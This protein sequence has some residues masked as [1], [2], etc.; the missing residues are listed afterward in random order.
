MN[1]NTLLIQHGPGVF[2]PSAFLYRW[3]LLT[4][5]HLPTMASTKRRAV[6]LQ[7][8]PMPG[9][10]PPPPRLPTSPSPSTANPSQHPQPVT[11]S[12]IPIKLLS[13]HW[14]SSLFFKLFHI[15]SWKPAPP[16]THAHFS[17]SLHLILTGWYALFFYHSTMAVSS[18][19][20]SGSVW[21]E[22]YFCN[23]F[24]YGE[25]EC[26]V[27]SNNNWCDVCVI[28]RMLKKGFRLSPPKEEYCT[29]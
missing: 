16:P 7:R 3:C 26:R 6:W 25:V 13:F 8:E 27:L 22:V 24:I 21:S 29:C 28:S 20:C 5:T 17:S 15:L 23:C 9:S 14:N 18:F 12:N 4:S 2:N 10:Q 1:V 19:S 11:T